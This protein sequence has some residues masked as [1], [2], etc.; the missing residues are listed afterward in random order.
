MHIG[1]NLNDHQQLQRKWFLVGLFVC[2]RRH[3]KISQFDWN[4]TE[5]EKVF[6]PSER[7]RW[8]HISTGVSKESLYCFKMHFLMPELAINKEHAFS[9]MEQCYIC[10]CLEYWQIT[11]YPCQT[12]LL[13]RWHKLASTEPWFNPYGVF[14]VGLSHISKSKVCSPMDRLPW[15]IQKKW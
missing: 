12:D 11:N 15:H 6:K 10:L 8:S 9:K 14:P 2:S 13:K 5:N 4:W 1:G 7:V 3:A